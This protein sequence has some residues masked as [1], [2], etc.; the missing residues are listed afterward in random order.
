MRPFGVS[1]KRRDTGDR[2]AELDVWGQ[3]ESRNI[4][5][6]IVDVFRQRDVIRGA[7]RE[8]M[9]REAGQLLAAHQLRILIR[10][11]ME[12]A[13]DFSFTEAGQRTGILI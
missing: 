9:V 2:T 5:V 11:I 13:A 1:L 12:C 7:Q 3:V 4:R 6:E 8:A 10:A